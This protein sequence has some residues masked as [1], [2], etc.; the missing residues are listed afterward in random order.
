MPMANSSFQSISAMSCSL[1]S[2]ESEPAG[3]GG[4]I[5]H[6]ILS[7]LQLDLGAAR[8]IEAF[9]ARAVAQ[10]RAHH[11]A[12]RRYHELVVD[13]GGTVARQSRGHEFAA[14]QQLPLQPHLGH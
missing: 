8:V 4:E 2:M 7:R 11:V 6:E 12:A 1:P 9:S 5:H 3:L 13:A 14:Q 10:P